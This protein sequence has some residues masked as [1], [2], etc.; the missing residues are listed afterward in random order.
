MRTQGCD[1][2]SGRK[3]EE[4]CVCVRGG[5]KKATE[6]RASEARE[7]VVILC[8]A[9]SLMDCVCVCMCVWHASVHLRRV[10]QQER[11]VFLQSVPCLYRVVGKNHW[12]A[13]SQ[14]P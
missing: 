13:P 4:G 9:A 10:G 5:S 12:M 6:E 2:R 11:A 1:L 3:E 7:N 14:I 8:T